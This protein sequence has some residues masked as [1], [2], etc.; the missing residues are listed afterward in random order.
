MR[1]VISNVLPHYGQSS[2]DNNRYTFDYDKDCSGK[3]GW[4]LDGV[5]SPAG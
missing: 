1:V 4:S 3:F 5:V 2:F